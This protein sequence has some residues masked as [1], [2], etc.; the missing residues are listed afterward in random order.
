MIR[1]KKSVNMRFRSGS[2]DGWGTCQGL[3]EDQYLSNVRIEVRVRV[4]VE[5]RDGESSVRVR[6]SIK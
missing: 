3:D 6:V 5:F 2:G 1:V 4:I